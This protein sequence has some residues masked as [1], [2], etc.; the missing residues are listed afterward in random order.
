MTTERADSGS[1][2]ERSE[3]SVA[4]VRGRLR[5]ELRDFALPSD[6]KPDVS[7]ASRMP[8]SAQSLP[9]PR[10]AQWVLTWGLGAPDFGKDEKQ[11]WLVRFK[12]REYECAL[13]L[14]KFGLRLSLPDQGSGEEN[15]ILAGRIVASIDRAVRVAEEQLDG[16]VEAQ[17]QSGNLTIR[18]EY[19]LFDGMYQHFR[20][21]LD[22]SVQQ[23]DNA[24]TI[25][26][27][28]IERVRDEIHI[29]LTSAIE[30]QRARFYASVAMVNAYFGMLEHLLVLLWP[31]TRY[32][33]GQD[34]P[35]ELIKDRWQNKFKKVFDVAGDPDAKHIY[36]RLRRIAEQYRNTYA[37][38]GFGK[39]RETLSV[40]LP[41]G[42][43]IPASLSDSRNRVQANFFPLGEP[44]ISEIA[45]VLDD[46]DSWLRAGP[47]A[48]GMQYI[49]SGLDVAYD[50]ES[51]ATRYEM[52]TSSE[53][54]DRY[55]QALSHEVD[56]QRNM[57]W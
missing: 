15:E 45:A 35:E 54:F 18:N 39:Q 37:H 9:V 38:G 42:P 31:F 12:Y 2:T 21:Q 25:S 47:A 30:T 14:F 48:F 8:V 6:D 17:V 20:S 29:A 44:D 4:E 7:N 23:P 52:M 11:A 55:L 28:P 19:H 33:P 51:I 26:K 34:N 36:D 57:D 53:T 50:A 10:L 43:P 46:A 49:E 40:H 22:E 32:E 5:G 56:N 1:T 27:N 3:S 24:G 13:G 41:G 16:Y